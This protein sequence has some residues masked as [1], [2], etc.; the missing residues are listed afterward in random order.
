MRAFAGGLATHSRLS[1]QLD[2]AYTSKRHED[3][4]LHWFDGNVASGLVEGINSLVQAARAKVHGYRSSRNLKAK[5]YL[6][7]GKLDLRLPA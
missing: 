1:P 3:G 4:K 6:L 7:A 5:V 2:V